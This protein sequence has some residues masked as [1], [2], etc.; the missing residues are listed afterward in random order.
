MLYFSYILIAIMT[1]GVCYNM[2]ISDMDL[3]HDR[4]KLLLAMVIIS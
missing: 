2:R 1:Y 4:I 3:S